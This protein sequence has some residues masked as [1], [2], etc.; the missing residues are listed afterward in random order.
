VTTRPNDDTAVDVVYRF[1]DAVQPPELNELDALLSADERA[2]RD[3]FRFAEAARVFSI[4]HGVTRRA[5]SRHAA[6]SAAKPEDWRF[7]C[8]PLNKPHIV[9]EQAGEPPLQ[10][11]L[12]HCRLAVAVAVARGTAIGVDVEDRRRPVDHHEIA[13]RFFAE[14]E[15]EMMWA[16]GPTK[17]A[18]RFFELWTLKEAYLKALGKGLTRPLQSVVFRFDG[19]DAVRLADD[20]ENRE[21][22]FVLATLDNDCPL[23]VAIMRR[24]APSTF[25]FRDDAS[26]EPGPVRVLR[27]SH[28]P[29]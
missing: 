14:S 13:R 21:W 8:D 9:P 29:A 11:N 23:A 4:A 1:V 17:A 25:T 22:T 27:T 15:V 10:F 28:E 3:R 7:W 6:P 5:L 16:L 26:G 18:V 24:Q 20:Q 19:E 2:R 12:S